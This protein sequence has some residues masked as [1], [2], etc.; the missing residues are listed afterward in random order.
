MCDIV[1][2]AW[3]LREMHELMAVV[4]RTRR[5]GLKILLAEMGSCGVAQDLNGSMTLY[6]PD[7]GSNAD[8]WAE[9][10]QAHQMG[11]TARWSNSNA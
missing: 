4:I 5:P 6:D 2:A 9:V 11:S 10:I 3:A 1:E 7:T 8:P